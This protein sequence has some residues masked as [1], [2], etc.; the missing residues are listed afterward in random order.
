MTPLNTLTQPLDLQ[1]GL[2][3]F[4]DVIRF[5]DTAKFPVALVSYKRNVS[6]NAVKGIAF[7]ICI[8]SLFYKSSKGPKEI[9]PE[10]LKGKTIHVKNVDIDREFNGG[11]LVINQISDWEIVDKFTLYDL[12][13][14]EDGLL[15]IPEA[16]M[17]EYL[18]Y[19]NNIEVE[20]SSI[21]EPE[22]VAEIDYM[23]DENYKE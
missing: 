9:R 23:E 19:Y 7:Y 11:K 4:I 1:P 5:K 15:V 18:E 22:E 2:Y 16:E 20:S 14:K 3:K 17:N 12:Y 21:D 13:K 10:D 8:E 6:Y